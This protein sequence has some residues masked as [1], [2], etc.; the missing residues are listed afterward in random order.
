MTAMAASMRMSAEPVGRMWVL[1][2]RGYSLVRADPT[3][4][5]K[6]PLDLKMKP[7]TGLITIVMAGPMKVF[8]RSA[9]LRSVSVLAG[10]SR[11]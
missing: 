6:G 2:L 11:A 3:A 4:A 10:R 1:V 7:A 5:A 8:R 9:G